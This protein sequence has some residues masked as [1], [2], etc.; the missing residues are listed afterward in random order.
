MPVSPW[1]PLVTALLGGF[2]TLYLV[3]FGMFHLMVFR[4]NRG[5]T[6]AQKIPHWIYWGGWNRLRDTYK[7][8][9]PRSP[10]YSVTH[11]LTIGSFGFA[12]AAAAVL[13]W[14]FAVGK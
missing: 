12:L 8:F 11:V 4:V 14:Q 2:L 13:W 5:L 6:D 7:G 1:S 3:A 9:Y 10:L